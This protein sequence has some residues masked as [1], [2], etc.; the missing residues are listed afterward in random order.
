MYIHDM[1]SKMVFCFKVLSTE[2]AEMSKE[3]VLIFNK[4]CKGLEQKIFKPYYNNFTCT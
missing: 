2:D 1:E 4:Q 3:C